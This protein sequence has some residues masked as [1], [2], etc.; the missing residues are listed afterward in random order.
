MSTDPLLDQLS[1]MA[2]AAGGKLTAAQVSDFITSAMGDLN[3]FE[4]FNEA[5]PSQ[6]ITNYKGILLYGGFIKGITV[7]LHLILLH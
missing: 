7:T 4:M 1:Q 6:L 2:K 5:N 3:N